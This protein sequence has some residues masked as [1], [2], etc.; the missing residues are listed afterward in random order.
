VLSCLLAL[1]LVGSLLAVG[2]SVAVTTP[3]SD[4]TTEVSTQPSVVAQQT[5]PANNTTVRQ[6]D[7]DSVGEDGDLGQVESQLARSLASRLGGSSVQISE[8]QYDRARDLLGDDYDRDLGKYVDVAGETGSEETAERFED[9]STQTQ[10]YA[11]AV[12]SYRETRAEYEEARANGNTERARELAREL[13]EDADR[14]NRTAS[15]L[16]ETYETLENQTGVD[17]SESIERIETTRTNV[18]EET[19]EIA[20]TEFTETQLSVSASETTVSFTDPLRLTGRLTT[21][22][23]TALADRSVTLR[24][25]AQR[26]TVETDTAGRF[27][28]QYRPTTL[29]TGE[30][31]LT[32]TYLPA[33]DSLYA[34]SSTTLPVTVSA[35]T[36]TV[37][38]T[39][40]TEQAAY[41]ESVTVSGRVT[42]DGLGTAAVPV[43]LSVDGVRLGS[44][45]TNSNGTFTVRGR[46]PATIQP[47]SQS[48]TVR[49]G[50]TDRA[51]SPVETREELT[52]AE[53]ATQLSLDAEAVNPETVDLSGRLV[54]DSSSGSGVSNAVVSVT[55]NGS[56]VGTLSTDGTG[57][58]TMQLTPEALDGRT[59]AVRVA[60]G[61]DGTNLQSATASTTVQ[62]PAV[63]EGAGAASSGDSSGEPSASGVVS[64]VRS[65]PLPIGGATLGVIVL[66]I[67]GALWL[68]RRRRDDSGPTPKP[69]GETSETTQS[70]DQTPPDNPTQS[71]ISTATD[72][73]QAN[74]NDDAVQ[75]AYA[76]VRAGLDTDAPQRGQQPD[77][78]TH[79]EFYETAAPTLSADERSALQTLTE[80]FERA[81]FTS[82][83]VGSEDAERSIEIARS[84]AGTSTND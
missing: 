52:V 44:T 19:E 83:G 38:V 25:G 29:P 64:V 15:A 2:P 17:L 4:S 49:V 69:D 73:L 81:T 75:Y 47:G 26:Q 79:W 43:T 41:N 45:E 72:R 10:E 67:A 84:L 34:G 16:S 55:Q 63:S 50:E 39:S 70:P 6:E 40:A 48:L 56:T 28:T 78:Q 11:D 13:Q 65:A 57:G 42:A 53:T 66:G 23:G 31:S 51:V 61:G 35:V 37:D 24:L 7:P 14:V 59:V 36:P 54:A 60:F 12:E 77:A 8:G 22:N 20:Q 3:N 9:A 33:S 46:L 1:L 32:A 82:G 68:V 27:S 80:G 30:Q 21:V 18:A 71:F 58:F 62:L 74:A 5:T 76:A